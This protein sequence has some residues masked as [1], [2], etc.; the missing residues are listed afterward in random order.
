LIP[1]LLFAKP[2]GLKLNVGEKQSLLNL[3]LGL[4][5]FI[6]VRFGSKLMFSCFSP[7][8]CERRLRIGKERESH[9]FSKF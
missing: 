7:L 5:S 9:W 2:K 8:V 4:F 6:I 3:T 1:I